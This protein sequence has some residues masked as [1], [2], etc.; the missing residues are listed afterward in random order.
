MSEQSSI[1]KSSIKDAYLKVGKT[2]L[3]VTS[4]SNSS[5]IVDLSTGNFF[6]FPEK[7]IDLRELNDGDPEDFQ[8]NPNQIT[9]VTP[10]PHYTYSPHHALNDRFILGVGNGRTGSLH[11][12][13]FALHEDV[14]EPID[15]STVGIDNKNKTLALGAAHGACIQVTTSEIRIIPTLRYYA[16]LTN[17]TQQSQQHQR[18]PKIAPI[19]TQIISPIS[20]SSFYQL[21]ANIHPVATL[22][23]PSQVKTLAAS[24][25]CT[26]SFLVVGC[27]SPPAVFLFRLDSVQI[28]NETEEARKK[29]WD[30]GEQLL[31]NMKYQIIYPTVQ[32]PDPELI[33]QNGMK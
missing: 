15:P 30:E 7:K 8:L 20:H 27:E 4:A 23:F 19:E 6:E 5:L 11:Q 2:V 26:R 21:P 1:T 22:S 28:A 9:S 13:I 29:M 14:I 24:T 18:K 12:L 17:R 25:I 33:I 31:N 10:I 3:F 32:H 16:H